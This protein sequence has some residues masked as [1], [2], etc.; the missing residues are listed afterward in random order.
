MMHALTWPTEVRARFVG[1]EPRMVAAP[2]PDGIPAKLSWVCIFL[3][4]PAL[5]LTRVPAKSWCCKTEFCSH[6]CFRVGCK[7]E[8]K[9][10]ESDRY[11][12]YF[13]I[14]VWL[15]YNTVLVSGV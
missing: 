11:R 1:W 4:W 13:Q 9:A 2:L 8:Y 5:H 12:L 6:P 10:L 3:V 14:E 7:A 15:I